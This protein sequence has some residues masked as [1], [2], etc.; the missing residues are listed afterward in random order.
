[1][2]KCSTFEWAVLALAVVVLLVMAGHFLAEGLPSDQ[3]WRVETERNDRPGVPVSEEGH[4]PSMLEGE[5]IDLNRAS[6]A[7]LER[8]PGIGPSR[9]QDIIKERQENG[10]FRTV[11]DLTRVKGIGKS[12]L[13]E[14]RPYAR[15]E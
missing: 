4:P 2:K 5:T 9:A 13:E 14:L 7:D 10:P 12:I 1:M 3:P 11:D 6:Q 8:L 15:V